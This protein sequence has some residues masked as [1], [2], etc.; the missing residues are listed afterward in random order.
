MPFFIGLTPLTLTMRIGL[1]VLAATLAVSVP[2]FGFVVALMGAFTTML[3]SFILPAAFYLAVEWHVLLQCV[4]PH[5]AS[6]A[7]PLFR[8]LPALERTVCVM[9][10]RVRRYSAWG[11]DTDGEDT[12]SGSRSWEPIVVVCR[13]L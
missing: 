1:A 2:N 7:W 12:G 9:A 6:P 8:R 4:V 10:K 11:P 13:R 5:Y 3:V